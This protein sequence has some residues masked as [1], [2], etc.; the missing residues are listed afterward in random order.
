MASV[1]R[2]SQEEIIWLYVWE[3]PHWKKVTQKLLKS[4]NKYALLF[5]WYG[6]RDLSLFNRLVRV[7]AFNF[8]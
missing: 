7:I 8:L 2:D 6:G 5:S 1:D 3:K 4:H